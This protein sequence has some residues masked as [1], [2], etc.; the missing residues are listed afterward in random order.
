MH[1]KEGRDLAPMPNAQRMIACSNTDAEHRA[2]AV[3]VRQVVGHDLKDKRQFDADNV[4]HNSDNDSNVRARGKCSDHVSLEIVDHNSFLAL[5]VVRDCVDFFQGRLRFPVIKGGFDVG[6]F[7][8]G[9]RP[10]ARPDCF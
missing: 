7:D 3:G 9:S 5:S 6:R 4:P 10:F 2:P 8:T 1:C